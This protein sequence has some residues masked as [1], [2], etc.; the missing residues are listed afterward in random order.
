MSLSTVWLTWWRHM[1]CLDI[2]YSDRAQMSGKEEKSKQKLYFETVCVPT[3]LHKLLCCCFDACQ[4]VTCC[5][6]LFFCNYYALYSGRNTC[7]T[8]IVIHV[9]RLSWM[10]TSHHQPGFASSKRRVS[11]T[12]VIQW[13]TMRLVK[14]VIR[15][16]LQCFIRMEL[17]L[18]TAVFAC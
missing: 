12:I 9:L 11:W 13:T 1:I 15:L 10:M 2:V 7:P 14:H 18:G 6:L 3:I 17:E 5:I 4:K 16:F 8:A